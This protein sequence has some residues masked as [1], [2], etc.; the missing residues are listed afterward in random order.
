M[1]RNARIKDNMVSLLRQ[2]INYTATDPSQHF[3][4]ALRK[5]CPDVRTINCQAEKVPIDSNSVK[6]NSIFETKA[7]LSCVVLGDLKI[8]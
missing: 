4:H 5:N 2:N 6:V 3:I 7:K 8:L 1:K